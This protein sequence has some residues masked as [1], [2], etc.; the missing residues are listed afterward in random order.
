MQKLWQITICSLLEFIST[1]KIQKFNNHFFF[2]F[3]DPQSQDAELLPSG[4]VRTFTK[5]QNNDYNPYDG[6]LG[7]VCKKRYQNTFRMAYN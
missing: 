4:G 1:V 3:A 5:E 2:F 7:L 6:K